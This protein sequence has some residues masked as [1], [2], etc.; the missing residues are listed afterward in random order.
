MP[1]TA[2]ITSPLAT[3]GLQRFRT[4]GLDRGQ[5]VIEHRAQHLDELSIPV[6][7]LLQLG[8]NLGQRRRQCPIT[9]TRA[10]L[11]KAPGFFIST[12]R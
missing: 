4:R 8:A 7:V 12:G 5:A 9:R 6:G 1:N 10:P 2:E 11:R 3:T